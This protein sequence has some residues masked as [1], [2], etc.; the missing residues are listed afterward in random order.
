MVG[1][2][3]S[4]GGYTILWIVGHLCIQLKASRLVLEPDI[5]ISVDTSISSKPEHMGSTDLVRSLMLRLR[6]KSLKPV[7]SG[8]ELIEKIYGFEKLL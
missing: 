4:D 6:A 5:C 7:C 8:F 3:P 1:D 2:R